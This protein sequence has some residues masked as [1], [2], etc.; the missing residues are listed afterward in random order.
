MSSDRTRPRFISPRRVLPRPP[1][2]EEPIVEAD[3]GCGC[4]DT[5]F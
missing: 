5:L 3:C 1:P 2:G 4:M